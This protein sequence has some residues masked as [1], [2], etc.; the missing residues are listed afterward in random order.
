M[1]VLLANLK[2]LYQRWYLWPAYAFL[3]L[4][5]LQPLSDKDSPDAFVL[6]WYVIFLAGILMGATSREVLNRPFVRC[7]P[8]H[9]QVVRRVVFLIGL[10][11]SLGAGALF[12]R[13]RATTVWE[14]PA[15]FCAPVCFT[16]VLYLAGVEWMLIPWAAKGP[17]GNI[18]SGIAGVAVILVG[19]RLYTRLEPMILRY[20]WGT[21]LG[22]A[23]IGSAIWLQMGRR[24]WSRQL[25]S[26]GLRFNR[27]TARAKQT[28]ALERWYAGRAGAVAASFFLGRMRGC[29]DYSVCRYIWGTLYVRFGG[30]AAWWKWLIVG[31]AAVVIASAC[32]ELGAAP[33][34]LLVSWIVVPRSWP[35]IHSNLLTPAG[36]RERF[37]AIL[38]LA[39]VVAGIVSLGTVVVSILSVPLARLIPAVK[40]WD[41]PVVCRPVPLGMVSVPLIVMPL[42]ATLFV[43]LPRRWHM[44]ALMATFILIQAAFLVMIWLLMPFHG[45]RSVGGSVLWL[46]TAVA[47]AWILFGIVCAY[48][49]GRRSVVRL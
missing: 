25:F 45:V 33:V 38:A 10:A 17:L 18:L 13:H 26:M 28:A 2:H 21:I 39:G 5:L 41:I 8:G 34:F 15:T 49:C 19:T 40:I 44:V 4:V 20:L 48:L 43:L 46:G 7:L 23:S 16:M 6:V 1:Q 31:L 37:L 24:E 14:S 12:L 11:V 32:T 30:L 42:L 29:L 36:R 47:L 22:G 3:G 35:P 27:A 9:P